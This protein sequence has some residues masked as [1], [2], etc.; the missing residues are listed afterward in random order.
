MPALYA[1]SSRTPGRA[2]LTAL[3]AASL[4]VPAG[5]AAEPPA[6]F[7]APA[8]T[9][10]FHGKATGQLD[11]F[12]SDDESRSARNLTAH[13]AEDSEPELSPDGTQVAFQS[14][15]AGKS[16][17]FVVPTTGGP[18]TQFTSGGSL[19]QSP[20]WSPDG[21]WLYFDSH[22]GTS[23][24]LCRVRIAGGPVEVL[25]ADGLD[26]LAPAVSPDGTKLAAQLR[27]PGSEQWSLGLF[28]PD[29]KLLS[30]LAAP[31]AALNETP[32][33]SP[34][35]RYLYFAAI[36]AAGYELFRIATSG[37]GTPEQLT[38]SGGWKLHPVAVGLDFLL[39]DEKTAAG[40][41]IGLLDLRSGQQ[42]TLRSA[43]DAFHPSWRSK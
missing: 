23:W 13:P 31:G 5:R 24:R 37:Q 22:R 18:P 41:R 1:Q 26:A 27:E 6:P 28:T 9:L 12:V 8:G 15:R 39:Y 3:L 10:V 11:I 33:F 14:T 21:R 16:H 17:V 38:R 32:S 7:G 36:T 42:R 34:D 30:K 4:L 20:C 19:D 25:T 40:W 29:G 2:F 35:G 43:I